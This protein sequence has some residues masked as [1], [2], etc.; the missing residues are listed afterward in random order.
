[1]PLSVH[2]YTTLHDMGDK[3]CD[4]IMEG[5]HLYEPNTIVRTRSDTTPVN[6]DP[7]PT[8][9]VSPRSRFPLD[10]IPTPY[11]LPLHPTSDYASFI[12]TPIPFCMFSLVLVALR[13][14]ASFFSTP[15]SCLRRTARTRS[16]LLSDLGRLMSPSSRDYPQQSITSP[17][18]CDPLT[19]A[20]QRSPPYALD[21]F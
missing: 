21:S 16:G 10:L 17:F 19:S 5:H 11:P 2:F 1:M 15:D 12:G 8:R 14:M 9:Y 18:L 6:P 20:R 13:T 3:S 7:V 4:M